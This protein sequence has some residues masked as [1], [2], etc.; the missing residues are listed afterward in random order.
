[1]WLLYGLCGLIAIATA[2]TFD[3][4]CGLFVNHMKCGFKLDY[5]TNYIR[6]SSHILQTMWLLVNEGSDW[7]IHYSSHGN[8]KPHSIHIVAF[9]L[10]SPLIG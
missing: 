5:V 4:Q 8:Q 3:P 1:M 2:A 10:K 9:L 6:K 7:Y